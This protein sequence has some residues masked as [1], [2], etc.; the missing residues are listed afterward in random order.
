MATN[1]DTHEASFIRLCSEKLDELKANPQTVRDTWD[2]RG[3]LSGIDVAAA[4]SR[5]VTP[6][7]PGTIHADRVDR[8][9]RLLDVVERQV[10][11]ALE[12]RAQRLAIAELDMHRMDAEECA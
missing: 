4:V 2:E 5:P 6:L 8:A 1:Y 7:R 9:L 12:D 10:D 3:D 11:A